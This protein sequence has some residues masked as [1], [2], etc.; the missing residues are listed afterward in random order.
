MQIYLHMVR[1][2]SAQPITTVAGLE[3][4]IVSRD[5]TG[6]AMVFGYAT[7]TAWAL[8]EPIVTIQPVAPGWLLP[9]VGLFAGNS[10]PVS[11]GAIGFQGGKRHE[12][13]RA[14]AIFG[15]G[16]VAGV[17][18][19]G[20]IEQEGSLNSVVGASEFAG[21]V[22]LDKIEQ[23][24]LFNLQLGIGGTFGNI[25][26]GQVKTNGYSAYLGLGLG[27]GIFNAGSIA[28]SGKSSLTVGAGLL[29]G[30]WN[31][32]QLKTS[33][34]RDIVAGISGGIGLINGLAPVVSTTTQVA[35]QPSFT[36]SK[37]NT[38]GGDDL[39]YGGGLYNVI[40]FL[41]STAPGVSIAGLFPDTVRNSPEFQTIWVAATSTSTSAWTP[42]Q[43]F[44][45]TAGWNEAFSP[46]NANL[47]DAC[48]GIVNFA[49]MNTGTG[50]DTV[51]G[52]GDD[53][54]ADNAANFAI[55]SF[56]NHFGSG[57]LNA[58]TAT[59]SLG[60]GDDTLRGETWA[61]GTPLSLARP[62]AGIVNYGLVDA[63]NGDDV[64]SGYSGT[65]A[66]ANLGILNEGT[67][68]T[69]RGRDTVDALTG[70]FSGAGL[71]DLGLD[72]DTL[73]GFGSGRFDGGGNINVV[74]QK[75]TLLLGNGT[76]VCSLSA[77]VG[78][79]YSLT[80][81]T[82]AMFVQGFELIGSANNPGSAIEFLAGQTYNVLGNTITS[83]PTPVPG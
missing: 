73:I 65:N 29:N 22:N 44:P 28:L 40:N 51:F 64:V 78:G 49:D 67:I 63:G 75:D 46:A 68:R 13:K 83:F 35:G 66:P 59:I 23:K 16:K 56:P 11:I 50:N 45:A 82:M 57:I 3:S 18:N 54:A 39:V 37:I 34:E 61:V 53:I 30:I 31:L 58:A 47:K 79:F 32:G 76:Y 81:D 5:T 1:I 55:T 20:E 41:N 33:N 26:F 27:F 4:H 7:A 43:Q 69:G 15:R 14:N 74:S 12:G 36:Q 19:T 21:I 60:E 10:L 2:S 70:G 8:A 77:G 38:A 17:L 52:A 9:F 6:T 24:G 42:A 80:K 48:W 72:D 25:N 62:P 71:T